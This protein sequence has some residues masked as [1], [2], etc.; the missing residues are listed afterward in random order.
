MSPDIEV[1][2]DGRYCTISLFDMNSTAYNPGNGNHLSVDL[3]PDWN[4][5]NSGFEHTPS[6][7]QFSVYQF[8]FA[9]VQ[10][11]W[12]IIVCNWEQLG[13]MEDQLLAGKASRG[14][15]GSVTDLKYP[16]LF[17]KYVYSP[18]RKIPGGYKW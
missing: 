3:D 17:E 2:A 12:K 15:S 10:G 9:K 5:D 1:S 14:W 16:K 18:E 6:R 7:F 11:E 4:M 8:H 13:D